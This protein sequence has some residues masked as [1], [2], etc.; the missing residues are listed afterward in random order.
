MIKKFLNLGLQPLANQYQKKPIKLST[1]NGQLYNLNIFFN[2]K[3]KLV[4]ISKRIPS[5]KMFNS[6]YPYRSSMS[7]TMR[8]SFK[9][10][11]KKIKKKFKPNLLLEI[12]SNDGALIKNFKRENVIGVEP[13]KNLAKITKKN[14]YLTYDKYWNFDLATKIKKKFNSVDIIYSAN[15]LTHISDLNSVFK[16]IKYLLSENGIVIIEDPSLLECLKKNSYDQFYNEHIYLFSAIAVKNL[17]SNYGFEIFDIENLSTHGGSL[18]YYIKRKTYKKQKIS[19]RVNNQIKKEIKFGLHKFEAYKKFSIN[20]LRSKK[21]L[22]QIL[23]KIKKDK[24][25]ILG[26][27]ATAKAVTVL[28]Y[29]NINK[30]LIYNFTDTTPEKINNYMPGKNIKILRYNK[31]ILKNYDYVFLG[32]WNFKKEIINK[33]KKFVKKGLKFITHI[34]YPRML[35]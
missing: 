21:D 26:Y 35:G 25:K 34:P 33:E 30:D 12:G 23:N 2:T 19:Y 28:N 6:K 18:R 32:A 27:G 7:H 14:G 13:C 1:S 16:S 31:N 24:K 20:T 8:T 17:L 22:L 10:L 4:S 3:S 5:E 9:N 29:C 11:S 15:T